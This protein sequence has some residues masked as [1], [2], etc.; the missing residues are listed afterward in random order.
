M[1][2]TSSAR[3]WSDACQ[4]ASDGSVDFH[5]ALASICDNEFLRVTLGFTL[6]VAD[7]QTSGE[8]LSDA[9]L[10]RAHTLHLRIARLIGDGDAAADLMI[11]HLDEYDAVMVERGRM[12]APRL[13]SPKGPK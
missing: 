4:Q 3:S 10:A 12:D 7:W 13:R 6:E 5:A 11:K 9:D 8:R 2:P 1:R